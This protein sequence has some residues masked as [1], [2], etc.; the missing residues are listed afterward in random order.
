MCEVVQDGRDAFQ[1]QQLA[2]HFLEQGGFRPV[3]SSDTA[4]FNRM[5]AA[6]CSWAKAGRPTYLYYFGRVQGHLASRE[7][8]ED[9]EERQ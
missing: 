4:L 7:L 1:G 9:R 2:G 8:Q 6:G 3:R 5:K